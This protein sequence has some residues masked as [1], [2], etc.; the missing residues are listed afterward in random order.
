MAE[1]EAV[2]YFNGRFLPKPEVRISP[3]DRGF[4][5]ADGVY[6]VV[7]FYGGR[8]FALGAHLERLAR[9]L[10]A[11]RIGG[12]EVEAIGEIAQR[13]VREN[14]LAEATCYVQVTRGAAPRRHAFP[15]SGTPPTV[16]A[17]AAPLVVDPARWERGVDVICVP[18]ERWARC[19][20]K[21]IALLPNVLANQR[22]REAGVE[23]AVLV[24]EGVV[25]EGSHTNVAAVFGGRLVTHP[26]GPHILPG[27]TRRVVLGLCAA[28]GIPVEER[29]IPADDLL[30]ADEVMLLSTTFEVLPVVR[31]DGRT[32]GGG[33]PGP[34]A[35]QL[36]EAFRARVAAETGRGTV[37]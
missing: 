29:P 18:D 4:L 30:R 25:T 33:V 17:S 28:L 35:R 12:V 24:R 19:D 14:G 32:I 8:P 23:E 27:V 10:A 31:V 26:E 20:V 1:R 36:L 6:E 3:D 7:R 9:S 16:Y 21:S 22:A 11:L 15:E 5:L 37:A 13:L 34:V 2:V